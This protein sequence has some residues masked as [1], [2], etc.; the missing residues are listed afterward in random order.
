M[1][2]SN[3]HPALRF[4]SYMSDVAIWRVRGSVHQA[5]SDSRLFSVS[6][7]WIPGIDVWSSEW[8]TACK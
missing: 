5:I 4:A 2:R 3:H 8:A 1:F 7:K 6:P